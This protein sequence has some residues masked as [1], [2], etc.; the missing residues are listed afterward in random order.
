[1]RIAIVGSR[2]YRNLRAVIEY[3]NQLPPDTVI[4]SGGARGVDITAERAAKERGL[5]TEI[6]KPKWTRNG[7]YNP[8]VGFERN[9]WIVEYADKVVAFWNNTSR[10]TQYTI[11]IARLAGK[12]VEVIKDIP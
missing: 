4:I 7:V 9:E 5:R 11:S 12:P 2:E 8:L 1:M 10:G 3:V 6:Y